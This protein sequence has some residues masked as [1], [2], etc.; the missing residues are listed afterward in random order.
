LSGALRQA[1]T[2]FM[3]KPTF[4]QRLLVAL[5]HSKFGLTA[6]PIKMLDSTRWF[7]Q[8]LLA[9]IQFTNVQGAAKA[10]QLEKEFD[11]VKPYS[12]LLAFKFLIGQPMIARIVEGD[13]RSSEDLQHI[14]STFRESLSRCTPYTLQPH[15][16]VSGF[17]LFVFFDSAIAGAFIHTT[18]QKCRHTD[19]RNKIYVRPWVIDV[20]SSRVVPD[21]SGWMY[22]LSALKPKTL[23]RELF[24]K[25]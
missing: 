1:G 16:V 14:A 18:Q 12:Q 17:L 20:P 21:L 6:D 2:E 9:P 15:G 22:S 23:A 8:P 4:Y 13:E 5:G 10:D 25:S 11:A 19:T 24:S 3:D 7:P